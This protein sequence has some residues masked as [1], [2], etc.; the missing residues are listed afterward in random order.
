MTGTVRCSEAERRA[1]WLRNAVLGDVASSAAERSGTDW[2]VGSIHASHSLVTICSQA[3]FMAGKGPIAR[4]AV[5][6]HLAMMQVKVVQGSKWSR[7][8]PNATPDQRIKRAAGCHALQPLS[9]E[10]L[11]GYEAENSVTTQGEA[12]CNVGGLG[13]WRFAKGVNTMYSQMRKRLRSADASW[14]RRGNFYYYV[15]RGCG[16]SLSTS[17]GMGGHWMRPRERELELA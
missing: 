17:D 16:L 6:L 10:P 2:V 5:G 8:R 13:M 7:L 12:A 14:R 15:C 1:R 11:T 3:F 4:E 9:S